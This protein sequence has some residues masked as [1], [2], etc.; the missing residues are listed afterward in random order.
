MAS[1]TVESTADGKDVLLSILKATPFGIYCESCY[2]A[3]KNLP[4][5]VRRKHSDKRSKG[6]NLSKLQKELTIAVD[7][8]VV[9]DINQYLTGMERD[10][11]H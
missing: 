9:D 6:V 3:V 8:F 1:A 10:A 11:V 5:H 4:N 2:C 7:S